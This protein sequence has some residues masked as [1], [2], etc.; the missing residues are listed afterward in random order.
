MMAIPTSTSPIVKPI[1]ASVP[2]PSLCL[3]RVGIG[4]AWVASELMSC[5]VDE[6]SEDVIGGEGVADD[7]GTI[8]DDDDDGATELLA[9]L[10]RDKYQLVLQKPPL[11]W[12][13]AVP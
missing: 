9:V 6:G 1:I 2:I 8:V 11:V 7:E 3:S 13:S 10:S 12:S 5:V 4:G